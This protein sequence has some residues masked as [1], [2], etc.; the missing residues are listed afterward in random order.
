MRL[1]KIRTTVA[2]VFLLSLMAC[3]SSPDLPRVTKA[4]FRVNQDLLE[5]TPTQVS[6]RVYFNLPKGWGKAS[7]AIRAEFVKKYSKESIPR[8]EFIDLYIDPDM[9]N[10]L[11]LL[12]AGNTP[13]KYYEEVYQSLEGNTLADNGSVHNEFLHDCFAINQIVQKSE[14]SMNFRLIAMPDND[15]STKFEF[16]YFLNLNDFSSNIQAIESSIGSLHCKN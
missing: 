13:I 7:E 1:L 9:K 6:E 2:C 14:S 16:I 11:I 8:I 5:P 10:S 15:L 4:T 12:N 3:S